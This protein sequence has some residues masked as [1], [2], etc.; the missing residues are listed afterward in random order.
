MLGDEINKDN[1]IE[2]Q[3]ERKDKDQNIRKFNKILISLVVVVIVVLFS[4]GVWAYKQYFSLSPQKLI[5]IASTNLQNSQSF[6]YQLSAN[7]KLSKKQQKNNVLGLL[8]GNIIISANGDMNKSNINNI[9]NNTSLKID[10]GEKVGKTKLEF[11]F[12]KDLYAKIDFAP[13]SLVSFVKPNQW[14]RIN[15]QN[16]KENKMIDMSK[17]NHFD[18]NEFI[19]GI[20]WLNYINIDKKLTTEKLDAQNVYHIKFNIDSTQI[21]DVLKKISKK[22]SNDFKYKDINSSIKGDVWINKDNKQFNKIIINII[23][24]KVNNE[25]TIIIKLDRYNNNFIIESPKSSKNLEEVLKNIVAGQ[26]NASEVNSTNL[27]HGYIKPKD[28]DHDGIIDSQ[29]AIYNTD[30]NNDDTDGDGYKDGEEVLNGYNPAGN[31][32]LVDPGLRKEMLLNPFVE[33]Y[34][35]KNANK[36]Q[37]CYFDKFSDVKSL[38]DCDNL[39][40]PDK[41]DYYQD[42]CYGMY[43]DAF[44]DINACNRMKDLSGQKN[45]YL[46]STSKDDISCDDLKDSSDQERCKT[47]RI[48]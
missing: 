22:I 6:H 23:N 14:V 38:R 24:N 32:K 42:F 12:N 36:K 1:I 48:K 40:D 31:G 8:L 20:D 26:I 17:V 16:L 30:I 5:I 45:C 18:I 43:A 7:V 47:F 39:L 27:E 33:C 9:K 46:T 3:A 15:Q 29:E 21:N 41:E 34:F 44:N 10:L 19:T 28:S 11:I 13:D 35:I 37:N 2:P 4:G 25:T